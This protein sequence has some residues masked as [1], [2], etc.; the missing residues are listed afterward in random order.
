MEVGMLMFQTWPDANRRWH[1]VIFDQTQAQTF[2]SRRD[3]DSRD[4]AQWDAKRTIGT[5]H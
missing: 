4:E 5:L 1:W 3:F 2:E